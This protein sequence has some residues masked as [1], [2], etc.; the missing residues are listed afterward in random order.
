MLAGI[1]SIGL[2]LMVETLSAPADVRLLTFDNSAF[3]RQLFAGM[4]TNRKKMLCFETFIPW[5][6][7]IKT[8]YRMRG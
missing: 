2:S 3:T 4:H 1:L 7:V 6:K 8:G 5:Y